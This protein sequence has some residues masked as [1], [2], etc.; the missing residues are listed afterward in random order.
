MMYN[1]A[2]SWVSGHRNPAYR[3]SPIGHPYASFSHS[4]IRR[5]CTAARPKASDV[6]VSVYIFGVRYRTAQLGLGNNAAFERNLECDHPNVTKPQIIMVYKSDACI[7]TNS[8]VNYR[9]VTHVTL[10]VCEGCTTAESHQASTTYLS[11]TPSK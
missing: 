9:E 1:A 3:L 6:G 2:F 4:D 7:L 8:M 5:R 10:S 11:T